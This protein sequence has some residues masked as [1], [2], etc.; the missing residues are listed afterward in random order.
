[1]SNGHMGSP[2]ARMT[3]RWTDMTDNI[4]FPQLRLRQLIKKTLYYL[5][6]HSAEAQYICRLSG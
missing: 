6:S 3:D 4:T 5:L 2:M 1:M